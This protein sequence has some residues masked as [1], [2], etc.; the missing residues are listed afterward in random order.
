MKQIYISSPL[1]DDL[2]ESVAY[3]RDYC[4]I[5]SLEGILPLSSTLIFTEFLNEKILEES[6]VMRE[7][8]SEL[9]KRSDELWIM[10]NNVTE[11]MKADIECAMENNIPIFNIHYPYSTDLYP[12]SIDRERLLSTRDVIFGSREQD[13]E[14]EIVLL[15]Q[16]NIMREYKTSQNQLY[17]ATHGPGTRVDYKSDTVH[18]KNVFDDELMTVGRNDIL[19]IVKPEVLEEVQEKVENLKQAENESNDVTYETEQESGGMG[20]N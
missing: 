8:S 9:L 7:L 5:S 16:D 17:I 19:G 6:N 2:D 3:A 10:G 11:F 1:T 13:Y 20:F 18:L 4:K 12:T 14:G 15:N